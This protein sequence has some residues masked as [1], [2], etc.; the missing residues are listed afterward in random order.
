M[1]KRSSRFSSA[2]LAGAL[3]CASPAFAAEL[4]SVRLPEPQMDGGKLLMQALK[5]RKTQREFSA[6]KL[7][8]PVLSNLLWAAWGINRPESGKRTAPSAMNKQ[9]VDVCV[10]T[11]DGV[12]LYDAKE[13]EL[14]Q[15]L[16]KDLRE[17]TGGEEFVATAPVSLVYVWDL[18]RSVRDE[19]EAA[20]HA[21]I[22][23]GAI[24]RN[25]YL[26]CA[27]EDLATVVRVVPDGPALAKAMGL[28]DNQ[29]IL[30]AQ[31]VGY[32]AE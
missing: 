24:V 22:T 3:A 14:K 11:A 6:K 26:F 19:D 29:R 12:Y 15:I 2:V 20:F 5:E 30:M 25:V 18:A 17:A 1:N 7:P 32:P 9:E 4:K 10:A 27:S 21:A 28:P 23:T 13:H 16:V 31:T 8:E